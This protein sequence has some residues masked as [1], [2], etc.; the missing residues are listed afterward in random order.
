MHTNEKERKKV[1]A[2]KIVKLAF[3]EFNEHLG[4]EMYRIFSHFSPLRF[5]DVLIC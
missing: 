2:G 1:R 5:F 4:T 3:I